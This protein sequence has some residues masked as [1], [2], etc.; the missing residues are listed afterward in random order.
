MSFNTDAISSQMVLYTV[1]VARMPPRKWRELLSLRF[2]L[3]A[4]AEQRLLR[5]S[6]SPLG[7]LH[8][9]FYRFLHRTNRGR[10]RRFLL[11]NQF[12]SWAVRVAAWFAYSV[13]L[14][15]LHGE[16]FGIFK[17]NKYFVNFGNIYLLIII[18]NPI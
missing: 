16:D 2:N 9:S 13:I 11:N 7:L 1:H 4:A 10:T 15:G 14:F 18:F 17:V 3:K 12:T 5:L 6:Y 8:R